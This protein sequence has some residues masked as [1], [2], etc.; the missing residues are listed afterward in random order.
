MLGFKAGVGCLQT[1]WVR[2]RGCHSFH[3]EPFSIKGFG[4][5]NPT[6]TFESLRPGF[7]LPGAAKGN[8][9]LPRAAWLRMLENG[10]RVWVAC[11]CDVSSA[12]GRLHKYIELQKSWT[13]HFHSSPMLF[14]AFHIF[15][16]TTY[17]MLRLL[18]FGS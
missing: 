17:G 16:G 1:V 7:L 3:A 18:Q 14:H 12:C 6:R 10:H 4:Q 2:L 8:G 15:H 11:L 5:T 13:F 9:Q